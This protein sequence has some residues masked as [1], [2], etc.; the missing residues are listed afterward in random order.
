MRKLGDGSMEKLPFNI[1]KPLTEQDSGRGRQ[2]GSV[3]Q[4]GHEVRLN[5]R[6]ASLYPTGENHIGSAI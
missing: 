6:S 5:C 2:P 1:R 4:T 3:V